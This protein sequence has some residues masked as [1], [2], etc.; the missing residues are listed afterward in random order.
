MF[1]A[2]NGVAVTVAEDLRRD[3][4]ILLE[5]ESPFVAVAVA[6]VIVDG[7]GKIFLET[8]ML[9]KKESEKLIYINGGVR[10][11]KMKNDKKTKQMKMGDLTESG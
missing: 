4:P 9:F 10:K 5:E 3:R 6:A 7:L 8:R 2:F 11:Q 1:V